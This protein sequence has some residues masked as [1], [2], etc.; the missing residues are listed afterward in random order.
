[1]S[2][3][4]GSHDIVA[5]ERVANGASGTKAPHLQLQELVVGHFEFGS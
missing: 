4:A 5:P 3:V 2:T 1:M